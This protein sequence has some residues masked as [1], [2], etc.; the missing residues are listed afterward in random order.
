MRRIGVLVSWLVVVL[1]FAG[2]TLHERAPGGIRGRVAASDDVSNGLAT[3]SPSANP[4]AGAF[5]DDGGSGDV[6]ARTGNHFAK[7]ANAG[8]DDFGPKQGGE[9]AAAA[10]PQRLLVQ[11]GQIRIE[12]AR[13]EDAMRDYVAKVQQWGGY[14]QKQVGTTLTIRLP[15]AKF[16]DAFALARATGRVLG[17]SREADD[18][19]EE[20][21]DL[22]IRIDNAKK[23][24]DRLV[25]ILQKADK[26][27]DILKVEAELR[28]LTE[29]IE[30]MEGRRKFLA[31]QVAMATL[32]V[33]FQ[34]VAEAPPPPKRARQQ[35][36]F[37]WVNRIGADAMLEDF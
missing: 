22:G 18:V 4:L 17:E 3:S 9:A 13:P 34:A 36:R 24:R 37:E 2:C 1:G 19:T 20:F 29:E 32:S 7:E 23:S 12:V 15:A 21:V 10:T 30:R 26:V 35:S 25:E 5:F 28:R 11:R 6:R 8:F 16:D 27:E 14:L 31:D 33:G